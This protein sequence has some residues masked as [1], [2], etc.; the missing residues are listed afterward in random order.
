[1]NECMKVSGTF[2]IYVMAKRRI[3]VLESSPVQSCFKAMLRQ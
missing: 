1:M 2:N 3:Q